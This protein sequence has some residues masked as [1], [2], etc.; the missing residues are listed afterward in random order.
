MSKVFPV[1]MRA[2]T[3]D[4]K[5]CGVKLDAG[6]WSVIDHLADERGEKWGDMARRWVEMAR[7]DV[8]GDGG[9]ETNVTKIIRSSA[10]LE[11]ANETIFKERADMHATAGPLWQSLGM[12]YDDAH[13]KRM[14]EDASLEGSA[15]MG[16]FDVA[17][18]TCEHGTVTIYIQNNMRDAPHV[19]ITTPF[20]PEQWAKAF[21]N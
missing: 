13:W 5:R 7:H 1:K 21:G 4:G 14:L 6:T 2:F 12:I 9:V 11:L 17:I 16:G 18:G 15:Q 19:A 20:T 3:L 8:G 10:M